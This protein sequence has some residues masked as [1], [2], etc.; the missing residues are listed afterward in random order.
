MLFLSLVQSQ[1]FFRFLRLDSRHEWY[2]GWLGVQ[3]TVP[4]LW[5][6]FVLE[7]VRGGESEADDEGDIAVDEI[8]LDYGQCPGL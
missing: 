3:F 6:R 5:R 4:P 2:L 8:Q 7:A 1:V